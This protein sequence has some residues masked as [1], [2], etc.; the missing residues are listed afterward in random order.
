MRLK[1][2]YLMLVLA[3]L[4]GV[5]AA[6][7][8]GRGKGKGGTLKVMHLNVW[9]QAKKVP[10][11]FAA[12]ADEIARVDPDVVMFSEAVSREGDFYLPALI[13]SLALRG[14][15]FHGVGC[16]LDVQ[17][18]SKY[19][20]VEQTFEIPTRDRTLRTTLDV[21]GRKVI[22][23]TGHLDYTHYECYMPRGYSGTTWKKIDAPVTDVDLIMKANDESLRDESVR[24]VIADAARQKADLI[25]F[26]GD[27]NEPS[28]LDWGADTRN[29]YDHNGAIVPW[30]CSS[31]L[32]DAGFRDAYREL[33]PSAVTHPGFTFPA[34]NPAVGVDKLA[35]A[36]EA[37]ERDRI[38]FIYFLP[39]RGWK[40][41]DAAV[42]GPSSSIVR[43]V[44]TP[45][46]TSDPFSIPTGLWPTDHKGILATF[47]Y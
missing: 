2:R 30:T 39:S 28:H 25:L 22:V 29:L 4:G 26:G 19:P 3:V 37:D 9:M 36:P 35:W 34:D 46:R 12:V 38:D 15:R 1:I 18:I 17:L 8:A 33:F 43:G 45:E 13:D 31:L 14:K 16:D 10:G 6:G 42:V 11:G 23:Y 32:Y 20:I 24:M 44:R 47:A 40:L 7:A 5:A 27:F 41:K 21:N